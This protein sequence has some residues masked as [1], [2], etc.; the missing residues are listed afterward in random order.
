M[1]RLKIFRYGKEFYEYPHYLHPCSNEAWVSSTDW[2]SILNEYPD[3]RKCSTPVYVKI[4]N[5]QKK[6]YSDFVIYK[7]LQKSESDTF[8]GFIRIPEELRSK[9]DCTS[10]KISEVQIS[11]VELNNIPNANR[12]KIKV[13][14]T[15]VDRWNEKDIVEAVNLIK[16]QS[17]YCS[18]QKIFV[19]RTILDFAVGEFIEIDP[20]PISRHS[21]FIINKKTEIEFEGMPLNK[22]HTINFDMIG[23]QKKVIDE[24]RR[25]IQLP[26][27][28]PEYFAKFDSK[29]PKGVLLYGPPGNGKTMIAKAVADSLGASFIEID[30]TDALQKYKGVGEYNLGKKFEEAEHKKNAV[31]FI[32]EIDSIASIRTQD[33]DGHEVTLVGKLLSLMDGINSTH[34]VVVIGATNRLYAIDPALRRPGR[35][36]KELE[37]PMPDYEA[38]LDILY[39][40]VKFE[41]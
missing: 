4:E 17:V 23:G 35:F 19:N 39:K 12:V 37:V 9:T 36:D 2:D 5:H 13:D 25:I 33:S 15:V 30:L 20:Q 11:V 8:Q 26:M 41:K 14:E 3:Y 31:I 18:E 1:N 27:N 38:R 34:R 24:L 6:D 29:P 16:K 22:N 28:F 21:P 32:D 40:Y 7:N 10:N